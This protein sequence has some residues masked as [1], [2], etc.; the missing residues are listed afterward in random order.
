[1][2]TPSADAIMVLMDPTPCSDQDLAPGPERRLAQPIQPGADR[3]VHV[4]GRRFVVRITPVFHP[5]LDPPRLHDFDFFRWLFWVLPAKL[6]RRLH[7]RDGWNVTVFESPDLR[8]GW[9]AR[10]LHRERV[11]ALR[12]ARDRAD[13]IV[14]QIEDRTFAP[15]GRR[16]GGNR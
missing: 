4:D 12:A 13:A 10:P 6:M 3:W 1:M 9:A 11:S 14:E 15:A 5:T 2:P 7:D 16:P 8:V